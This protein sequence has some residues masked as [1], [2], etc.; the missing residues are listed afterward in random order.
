MKKSLFIAALALIT[1]FAS[2]Q[3]TDTIVSL[4][5]TNKN[6]VLE[7]FTGIN[8]GYCPDGHRMANELA[9]ANPGRVSLINIHVG[10][11]AAN[12]YTTQWGTAIA[13]QTGLTGYPAGT[14]NRHVFSGTTTALNRGEWASKA[15]TIM[16]QTSPVNIAA[17]GVLDWATRTLTLKVQLYYT[18]NSDAAT[19][20]LNIAVVQDNVLGSQSGASYNPSQVVGNQY[21]HMHMLRDLITGQWGEEISTTTAGT[22]VEKNYT[23]TVPAAL[24]SP[25]AVDAE[26]ENLRFIVFVAEGQQEILTG[27]EAN[28]T[29]INMPALYP[30]FSDF[31]VAASNTCNDEAVATA[32]IKNS[33]SEVITSIGF[34]YTVGNGAAQT[35]TWT[36]NL[37]SNAIQEIQFPTLN[38]TANSNVTVT[39]NVTTINGE[40][41]TALAAKTATVKK[42]AYTCGGWML[43]ELTTDRY[44]SETS[45]KFYDPN[46]T[47]VLQGS[48]YAN[49][50]SSGTTVHQYDFTPTTT[51]CYRLEVL[52]SYGD[53]MNCGYGT[54]GFKLYK[55]DG[56]L[57]FS[58]NGKIDS[59]VSYMLNVDAPTGI[60]ENT[61]EGIR[62][63][64]NPAT[65]TINI[66]SEETV[67]NAE[68]YNLQGQVVASQ[69][70]N[71][72]SMSVSNIANGIY[73]LRLTTAQ[74]TTSQ[75]I[76]KQ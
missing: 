12:T 30:K 67:L 46:G 10:S 40:P 7:E 49:L 52:D 26:L 64:P 74:G 71:V 50:S 53:G 70:G 73:M 72:T 6:V 36:G 39:A 28:V 2:A 51:G 16:G 21:N 60:E 29:S 44:A 63:Y 32:K 25:T 66:I 35:Y 18:S 47:V 8:C 75:K 17:E 62:V 5:P 61:V 13:N 45:F 19:N 55:A 14:I 42:N 43:F 33:G 23:Y 11:Y 59:G 22:L 3:V 69:S 58:N 38:I 41:Y 31:K 27:I 20:K 57:I 37:A 9:A 4:T 54:G 56:S 34:E 48:G 24:G 65:S 15:S 1:G 68:L 76:V